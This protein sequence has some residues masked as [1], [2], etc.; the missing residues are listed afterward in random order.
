VVV[1]SIVVSSQPALLRRLTRAVV[2]PVV[3][4]VMVLGNDVGER[5]FLERNRAT[6]Q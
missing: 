3:A 6:R 2:M 4:A 5:S 1:S